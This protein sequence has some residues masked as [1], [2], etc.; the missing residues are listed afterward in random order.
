MADQRAVTI[1]TSAL[2]IF[3]AIITA[4][5]R[6]LARR[7][8]KA[9]FGADDWTI[10]AALV[11]NPNL[12]FVTCGPLLTSVA[13]CPRLVCDLPHWSVVRVSTASGY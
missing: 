7:K 12:R 5:L 6:I 9:G 4:V 13:F 8:C 3:F 10:F 11:C 1:G 2:M